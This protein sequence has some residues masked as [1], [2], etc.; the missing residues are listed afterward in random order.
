M[1]K[2]NFADGLAS[3]ATLVMGE[4]NESRPLAVISGAEVQ[5]T[6]ETDPSELRVK[7]E[8]DLYYPLLEPR[9][10]PRRQTGKNKIP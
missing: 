9:L 8:D 3:A 10:D 2:I 5:F 7:I 4:G 6:S 1:T